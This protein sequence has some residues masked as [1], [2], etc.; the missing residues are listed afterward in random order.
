MVVQQLRWGWVGAWARFRSD[1]REHVQGPCPQVLPVRHG[2]VTT[3]FAPLGR[4]AQ[5]P[6]RADRCHPAAKGL[7]CATAARRRTPMRDAAPRRGSSARYGAAKGGECAA[8]LR[9]RPDA[10]LIGSQ[11][12]PMREN[13]PKSHIDGPSLQFYRALEGF[14]RIAR[15]GGPMRAPSPTQN[16][17]V[18]TTPWSGLGACNDPRCMGS[19]RRVIRVTIYHHRTDLH[20]CGLVE[21]DSGMSLKTDRR[22]N[23]AGRRP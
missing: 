14:G 20:P 11:R 5:S 10:R 3:D 4:L 16:S 2:P 22:N 1:G 23:E 9:S 15:A 17:V 8:M 18:R 21:L 6:G 12:P 13:G 19:I 7:Q